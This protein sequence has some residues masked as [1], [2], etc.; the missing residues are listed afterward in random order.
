MINIIWALSI[1]VLPILITIILV[2][3]YIMDIKIYDK[4]VEGAKEG[5]KTSIKIMPYLLALFIAVGMF[6][7]IG[8]MEILTDILYP[9]VK[10]FNIPKGVIPL[11]IIR[12]ISGSGALTV[13]KDITHFFGPDSLEGRVAATMMGSAETIF[14]TMAVYFGA[15]GIKKTRYTLWIALLS[16]IAAV[17]SAVWICKVFFG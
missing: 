6:R 15:I 12:P 16:H 10:P 17:L 7:D 11:A 4:F 13:V 2:H 9:I 3:G 1:A 5:I 14:Y 8:F